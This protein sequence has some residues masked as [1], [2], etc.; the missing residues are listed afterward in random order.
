M[1]A[2]ALD[3]AVP[4][5]RSPWFSPQRYS[6]ATFQPS[7]K[8]SSCRPWRIA[9]RSATRSPASPAVGRA[10]QPATLPQRRREAW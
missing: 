3:L 10:P 7:T 1:T 6:I 5:S 9:G 8:P 2:K 4:A